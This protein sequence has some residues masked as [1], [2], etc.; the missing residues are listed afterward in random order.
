MTG[1]RYDLENRASLSAKSHDGKPWTYPVIPHNVF[2]ETM[3][4]DGTV[5]G[6]G[7]S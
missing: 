7:A 3:S 5:R 1:R 6:F 2:A 4:L